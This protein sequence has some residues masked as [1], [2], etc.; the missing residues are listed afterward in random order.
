MTLQEKIAYLLDDYFPDHK[1]CECSNCLAFIYGLKEFLEKDIL[2]LIGEDDIVP[3]E[4]TIKTIREALGEESKEYQEI[5]TKQLANVARTYFR[6][7][8]KEYLK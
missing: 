4:E 7:K 8:L 2:E 5:K 6:L 3:N 1:D